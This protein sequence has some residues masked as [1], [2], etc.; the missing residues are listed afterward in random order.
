MKLFI[1]N[2]RLRLRH[3]DMLIIYLQHHLMEVRT[4]GHLQWIRVSAT[5]LTIG[6]SI[7]L[8]SREHE[9]AW[10]NANLELLERRWAEQRAYFLAHFS[11]L[12]KHKHPSVEG[13]ELED[14]EWFCT[15]YVF[16]QL[17]LDEP[18]TC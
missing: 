2:W 11:G 14:V 4:W 5:L 17:G 16:P 7:G 3:P 15:E 13:L 9:D 8:V 1:S 10:R 12:V 6:R 18:P